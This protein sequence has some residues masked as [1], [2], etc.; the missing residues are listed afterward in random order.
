MP[1]TAKI[2]DLIADFENA[3]AAA[4]GLPADADDGVRRP[5]ID[6]ARDA[7]HRLVDRVTK[8]AG[9]YPPA[10]V[11]LP[12]GRAVVVTFTDRGDFK[13]DLIPAA[14]VVRV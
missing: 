8:L 1:R 5:V 6:A 3:C 14:S 4:R 7:T 9:W 10:V 13:V 11:V 12:D 2:V